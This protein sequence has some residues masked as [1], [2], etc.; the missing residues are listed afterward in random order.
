MPYTFEQLNDISKDIYK[1]EALLEQRDFFKN[2]LV[3]I[4][5]GLAQLR[6]EFNETRAIVNEL[7][8]LNE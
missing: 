3:I 2:E 8:L 4:W 6:K 5:K 7:E 1:I